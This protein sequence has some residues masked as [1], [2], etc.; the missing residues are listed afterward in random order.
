MTGK[1]GCGNR[2]LR[3]AVS[4]MHTQE[5][6]GELE[7]MRGYKLPKSDP[8]SMFPPARLHIKVLEPS[9]TA[10]PAEGCVQ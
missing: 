6:E 4:S 9:K 7:V 2:K 10:P 8:N 5:V 3:D 1:S